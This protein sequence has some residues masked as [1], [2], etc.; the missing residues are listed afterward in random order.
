MGKIVAGRVL[1]IV[2][3]VLTL[4]TV[5]PLVLGVGLGLLTNDATGHAFVPVLLLIVLGLPFFLGGLIIA[6]ILAI[7]GLLLGAYRGLGITTVI[8]AVVGAVGIFAW[9]YGVDAGWF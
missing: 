9:I 2:A 3:F 7:I 1:I 4:L 6:A 5:L 8:L